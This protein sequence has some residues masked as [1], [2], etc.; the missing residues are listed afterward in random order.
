MSSTN[1]KAISSGG[2]GIIL[3]SDSQFRVEK[4]NGKIYSEY[5]IELLTKYLLQN[6]PFLNDLQKN[7]ELLKIPSNSLSTNEVETILA[8]LDS[9]KLLSM[10]SQDYDY[11]MA[12]M[13][14]P[15]WGKTLKPLD[16]L[17]GDGTI[18]FYMEEL[19]SLFKH[20]RE[21]LIVEYLNSLNH[22]VSEHIVHNLGFKITQTD[23]GFKALIEL[24]HWAGYEDSNSNIESFDH[25]NLE[26]ILYKIDDMQSSA[27]KQE[28]LRLLLTSLMPLAQA[29]DFIHAP[30]MQK[31]VSK[32]GQT[33][34][35]DVGKVSFQHF[36]IK[37]SNIF[38]R[39]LFNSNTG[40]EY[41]NLILGDFGLSFL[42]DHPN[43]SGAAGTK[44]FIAPELSDSRISKDVSRADIY[45][46]GVTLFEILVGELPDF[47][48]EQEN[49][50]EAKT[51]LTYD[52][53]RGE[54]LAVDTNLIIS[55]ENEQNLIERGIATADNVD[56]VVHILAKAMSIDP[57][58]RYSSCVE[59]IEDLKLEVNFEV[60]TNLS[61]A[62]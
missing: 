50:T 3:E 30:V 45:S 32:E 25:N 6:F 15:F 54:I 52:E 40:E 16:R 59:M 27:E 19:T 46:F 18:K 60:P 44:D 28:V 53:T 4:E 10:G 2:M 57:K 23:E 48:S 24:E 21:F 34:I 20:L 49:M 7:D 39:I 42:P 35:E 36:D 31:R 56:N 51:F 12:F 62:S 5:T 11:Y 1:P 14:D 17:Y 8:A 22:P 41:I 61:M 26:D 29:I 58:Y 37:P 9:F 33:Q 47:Y 13:E 38:S 55:A 43:S